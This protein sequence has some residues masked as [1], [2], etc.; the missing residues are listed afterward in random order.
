MKALKSLAPYL[1]I[2]ALMGVVGACNANAKELLFSN[3]ELRRLGMF[4]APLLV[5]LT[6]F[7]VGRAMRLSG[8]W[9]RWRVIL[10]GVLILV[11]F[12]AGNSAMTM[13]LFGWSDVLWRL[14]AL[15][16]QAGL[17]NAC[18]LFAGI[19]LGRLTLLISRRAGADTTE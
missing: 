1:L 12:L 6:G 9:P 16:G 19:L 3:I 4:L 7:V 11:L 14:T 8:P 15:A 10:D 17:E 2:A 5:T 13:T 18:A